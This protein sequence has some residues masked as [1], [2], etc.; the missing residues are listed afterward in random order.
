MPRRRAT[1][2]GQYGVREAARYSGLSRFMVDYLVRSGVVVPVAPK[3]GRGR[4]RLFT[5]GEVVLLRALSHLLNSGIEVR[6]LKAALTTLRAKHPEI[7]HQS[8]P[9]K[10][11]VTDGEAVF[12]CDRRGLLLDLSAGGQL[13]FAFVLEMEKARDHV[14]ARAGKRL[15]GTKAANGPRR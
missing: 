1:P 4:S 13:A 10:Y 12:Y 14:I 11:L 9:G 2:A 5:F 6:R 7:T 15:G 3:P 8:L